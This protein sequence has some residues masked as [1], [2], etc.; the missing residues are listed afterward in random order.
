MKK[1][2]TLSVT[3][4]T[5]FMSATIFA[6]SNSPL[7]DELAF[8]TQLIN[9]TKNKTEIKANLVIDIAPHHYVYQERF[10]FQVFNQLDKTKKPITDIK[11]TP[12]F[13][14]AESKFDEFSQKN[15]PVYHGKTIIP[16][17]ITSKLIQSKLML[18][19][20]RQGCSEAGICYPPKILLFPLQ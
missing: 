11:I 1:L 15:V 7:P 12:N 16:L 14:K 6:K 2:S 19:M 5:L 8:G 20:T 17:K 13:P 10:K 3:L 9:Q 18:Q 4:T